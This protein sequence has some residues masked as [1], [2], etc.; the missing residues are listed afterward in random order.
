[1]ATP[2]ALSTPDEPCD[3]EEALEA[4]RAEIGALRNPDGCEL[5]CPDCTCRRLLDERRAE[6]ERSSST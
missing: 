5:L 1:M 6:R 4:A 2:E 3:R